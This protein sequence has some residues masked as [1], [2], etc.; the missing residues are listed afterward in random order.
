MVPELLDHENSDQLLRARERDK[1]QWRSRER[2]GYLRIFVIDF[3]SALLALEEA[4]EIFEH[5]S[6]II[7]QAQWQ[8]GLVVLPVGIDD[9]IPETIGCL[10]VRSTMRVY[11]FTGLPV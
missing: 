8:V 4:F 9:F 5:L 7:I 2:R 3:F 6:R 10:G 11:H 1:V